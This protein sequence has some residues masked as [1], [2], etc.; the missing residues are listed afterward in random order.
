MGLLPITSFRNVI[1]KATTPVESV[2]IN[3]IASLAYSNDFSFALFILFQQKGQTGQIDFSTF[4]ISKSLTVVS[5]ISS[6]FLVT[7]AVTNL[8]ILL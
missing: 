5:S 7:I 8:S 1:E 3:F 2:S 6:F 4:S